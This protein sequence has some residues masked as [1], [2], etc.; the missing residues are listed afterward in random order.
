MRKNKKEPTIICKTCGHEN[1]ISLERCSVC[2]SDLSELKEEIEYVVP[3]DIIN[4][5]SLLLRILSFLMPIIGFILFFVK[6]KSEPKAAKSYLKC[7]IVSF[8]IGLIISFVAYLYVIKISI[9]L[10]ENLPAFNNLQTE[11]IPS[12]EFKMYEDSNIG[13]YDAEYYVPP[14]E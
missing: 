13:A 1:E 4:K 7:A 5:P 14:I 6:K 11:E 10:G 8:V 3:P 12:E 9:N 2:D